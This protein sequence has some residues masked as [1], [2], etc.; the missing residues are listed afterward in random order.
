MPGR[1]G[2]HDRH[3][4]DRR[5]GAPP[6]GTILSN[7]ATSTS[8]TD[9]PNPLNNT[10]TETT[11][12]DTEADLAIT[13]TGPATA[14]AG[15]PAGFDYTITVSNG[16]PSDNTGG[17]TVSDTLDTGPDLPGRRQLGRRARP[18]ASSSSCVNATGLAAGA[19]QVFTVH[20]TL[21]QTIEAGVVLSN[22]ATRRLR[23]HDRPERR[24]RH[25]HPG[26][27]DDRPGERRRST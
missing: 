18:P 2:P 1:P 25:Q 27:P 16:G 20:V 21:D 9:D 13:K 19:S 4:R 24:Q 10:D 22:T 14:T 3:H 8:T 26:R 23:R 5:P 15:D 7:T 6:T 11:T 17:F 12:V